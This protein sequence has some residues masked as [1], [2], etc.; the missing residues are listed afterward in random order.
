PGA[1]VPFGRIQNG[2]RAAAQIV[3]AD[4]SKLYRD[5]SRPGEG[6]DGGDG[7]A[8]HRGA[9]AAR[10]AASGKS[11]EDSHHA[12]ISLVTRKGTRCK[13]PLSSRSRLSSTPNPR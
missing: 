7:I 1:V 10:A 5:Q 13:P 4:R 12:G 3:A 2:T 9:P 11:R 6:R 8:R